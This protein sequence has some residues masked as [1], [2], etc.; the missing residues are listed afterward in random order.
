MKMKKTNHEAN[1][2]EFLDTPSESGIP[3]LSIDETL[4]ALVNGA[5]PNTWSCAFASCTAGWPQ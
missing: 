2:L 3:E 1:E 4:E 5:A